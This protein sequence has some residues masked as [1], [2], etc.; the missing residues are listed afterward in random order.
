[1]RITESMRYYNLLDDIAQAQE[2]AM[3]AQEQ[4]SSGKRIQRPDEDPLA[5]TDILRLNSE[6][7]EADQYLRNLTFA[8]S[9]LQATDAVLD[10]IEQMVERARTLGQL[11]FGNSQLAPGYVAELTA[12]RDQLITAANTTYGG[13]YIFGGT[14]TTVATYVKNPD[15]TVTYNGND[16]NM[17][18]EINRGLSV[19]T[20]IPGTDLFSSS[21][22]I[23]QV[24]S[25]LTTAM[26]A[27]DKPGID[28]ALKQIEQFTDV[29]SVARSKV[30]GY[31]NL[32]A[33]VES[34]LSAGK[35][36]R[37]T[38]LSHEEAAD[39]AAAISE[40]TLSQNGLQA[41]LAVGARIS[42]LSILDYLR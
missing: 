37:A 21:I 16:Q 10:N 2:R 24:M 41:T 20:Q 11:G 28:A 14:V 17:P 31:V 8:K 1:M 39:L 4:V 5:A 12:L 30:G 38:E 26:Q 7:S 29:M 34:D 22:D 15:T 18:V 19:D 35:L 13:R 25:D 23:F 9:K 33:R 32:T 27:G 42:Q 40:L 3:K 6:G 36:A